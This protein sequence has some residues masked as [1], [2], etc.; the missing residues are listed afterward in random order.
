MSEVV[1]R[2]H[3]I[4]TCGTVDGPGIRYVVFA[5]GCPLRCMYCHNPDT[6][7]INNPNAMRRTVSELMPD[8]IKYKSYFRA[9]GG[10]VT[11][12]GG[13]PLMQKEFALELFKA[14]KQEGLHT[15]L[16]TSGYSRVDALTK[17]ILEYTDLVLLDFK[18]INPDTYEKVTGFPIER[19]MKFAKYLSDNNIPAWALFVLVPGLTDDEKE[20]KDLA[21]YLT[22]LKNI[23][24]VGVH[25]FHQMGAYKWRQLKLDYQLNNAPTPTPEETEKVRELFKSYGFVVR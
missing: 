11:L 23:E 19:T 8:I 6:W 21:A 9:T 17:T 16:D 1:G 20:L 3:S 4:E 2:I 25:P 18:S 14:C 24:R 7:S 13:D 22:T 12:T 5:Q 15:C 10:G